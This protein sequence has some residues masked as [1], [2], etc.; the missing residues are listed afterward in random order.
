MVKL[1]HTGPQPSAGPRVS[2]ARKGSGGSTTRCPPGGHEKRT[3][4]LPR[5]AAGYK[6]PFCLGVYAQVLL[7]GAA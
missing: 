3:T 7:P 5:A 6:L 2:A 1:R 4:R